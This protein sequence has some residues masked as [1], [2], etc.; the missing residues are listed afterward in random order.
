MESYSSR[1]NTIFCNFVSVL[2]VCALL[3]HLSVR[4]FAS[5]QPVCSVKLSKIYDMT[6]NSFL[7]A[8]QSNIAFDLK[9]N[10]R[11]SMTWNTNQLFVMVTASFQTPG[12]KRNEQT[13]YDTIIRDKESA[14]LVLAEKLNEYVLRDKTKDL[15]DRDVNL[16]VRFW[17]MPIVGEMTEHTV[18]STTFKTPSN[19]FK[20]EGKKAKARPSLA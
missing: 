2:G 14:S 12:H 20:Y 11:S 16:T 18:C 3:N 8:E 7:E 9:S 13:I 15:R 17:Q 5:P 6:V 10:F 4:L 19:I 1:A